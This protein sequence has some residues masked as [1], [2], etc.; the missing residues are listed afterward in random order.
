MGAMTRSFVL[1]LAGLALPAFAEVPETVDE[2][3]IPNYRRLGPGLAAAGQPSPEA[4]SKLKEMGFRTVINLRTEREGA[5]VEQAT[6]EAAGLRYVWVPITAETFSAGDVRAVASV[7]EDES[8]SPVL[9]HCTIANR[10][11]GVWA[12]I[13]VGRGKSLEEAEAEGRAA[14][15]ATPPMIEAFRRVASA[16]GKR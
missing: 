9:I 7:L 1:V 13:L 4:L 14:G 5:K 8:A 6:A 11:G 2:G 10:V 15:L 3:A 12:A 16:A